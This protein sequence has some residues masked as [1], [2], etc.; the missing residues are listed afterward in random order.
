MSRYAG[1]PSVSWN[2]HTNLVWEVPPAQRGQADRNLHQ[3]WTILTGLVSPSIL[4]AMPAVKVQVTERFSTPSIVV[5]SS[6]GERI[7]SILPTSSVK[8]ILHEFGH[9]IEDHGSP[10][11]FATMHSI[12]AT[13]A[14]GPLV[15]LGKL[16]PGTTYGPKQK[17]LA[18]S[19]VQ[20]YM[21]RHYGKHGFTEIL[22]L[23]LERFHSPASAREFLRKDGDYVMRLLGA[24]QPD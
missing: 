11:L 12:R 18:G 23:G 13:R 4:R 10:Q 19:F 14:S 5:D 16:I 1:K 22:S 17:A 20:A 21:G 6:T 3:A 7:L 15:P 9:L 24:I 2:L 8:D